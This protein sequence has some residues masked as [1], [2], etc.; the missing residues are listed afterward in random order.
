MKDK[1][2]VLGDAFDRSDAL[3]S[4][5]YCYKWDDESPDRRLHRWKRFKGHSGAKAIVKA[6]LK[7]RQKQIG[8]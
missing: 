7:K 3:Y 2:A 6:E 4:N 8:R 5:H 1:V